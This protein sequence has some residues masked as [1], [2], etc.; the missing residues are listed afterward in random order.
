LSPL[1]FLKKRKPDIEMEKHSFNPHMTIAYRDLT[2][3]NFMA[4]WPEFESRPFHASF[5]VDHICLLK[6]NRRTWDILHRAPLRRT[7]S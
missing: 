7:D 4:A 6:H 1:R 5:L 3:E 2:K